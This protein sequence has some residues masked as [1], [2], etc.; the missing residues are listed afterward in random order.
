MSRRRIASQRRVAG[1]SSGAGCHG[2]Q[3]LRVKYVLRRTATVFALVAFAAC[4][5][6]AGAEPPSA[7]PQEPANARSSAAE[8]LFASSRPK[9]LQIRTL[10]VA[11]GRQ[12]SIGSGFLVS[13]DGL[14]VT[15]YHVVSQYA[16]EPQTYRLEYAAADGSRG[17]VALVALDVPNDLAIVRLDKRD[18]PYF[19]FD[20]QAV[21]GELVKG[22]R[23]Y[24]L[25][26]PLDLGFT[27][28]EG[29]YNGRVERSY[30]ERIH[31]TGAINPGMSG[32]PA[33][34]ARGMVAGIN[35]SKLLGGE[36]VSFL[37]PAP[38][39]ANLLE[40]AKAATPLAPGGFRP[41]IGR[42]LAHWQAGLYHTLGESGFRSLTFGPYQA[43]ESAAPWFTCW[44]QTNT[45]QVPKARASV[46]STSC[47]SD[48]RLFVAND[49]NTGLIHLTHS[50]V[51]T[52]DLNP[53][54]FEAFLSQQNQPQWI[55]GF[56]RKW[57]TQ[58]RCHEDFF[59][60]AAAA[61]GPSLRVVW[62]ARAYREFGG[63]YDISVTAVT[64]DS[65]EEALVSRLGLQG[66]GYPEAT[67]LARHFLEAVRWV[68]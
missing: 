37:V 52:V 55:G 7:L 32:G 67:A 29:T 25:G 8:S 39:A 47:N 49:L 27:I 22:E 48:T 26:N 59:L 4:A 28:V 31:F 36:L 21:S 35:V 2:D 58:Q 64:Q 45:G 56:S 57:L 6:P 10:I 12:F 53:F 13:P 51:K 42:Q 43:P 68:R 19:R 62:C 46:N 16:L 9:L 5:K 14:A 3:N 20:D 44:A 50:Y 34:T 61:G 15:N 11:A 38:F 24:S 30:N 65:G 18:A 23:L 63:L 41:E 60:A 33:L 17:E 66:V 1:V 40:Q 54:Q